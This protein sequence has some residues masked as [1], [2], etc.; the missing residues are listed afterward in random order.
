MARLNYVKKAQDNIYQNGKRVEY[1]SKKGKREGQTLTT[2]DRSQPENSKDVIL[3]KKGEP[4]YWWQFRYGG[5]RISKERPRRSALTQSNYYATLW[6]IE[7]DLQEATASNKDEFDE[8]K[9]DFVSRAEELRDE[10]QNSLD[11]IPENLQQAPTGELLQERIDALENFISE[12]E[13]VECEDTDD[14]TVWD[15]IAEDNPDADDDEKGRLTEERVQEIV[16]EA[17]EELKGIT[18]E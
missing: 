18:C 1:V 11:N 7:D 2:V 10:C 13:G 4:Y 14:D 12:L 15:E 3:I 17:L 6:D 8:I 9:Q 5:K 16:D